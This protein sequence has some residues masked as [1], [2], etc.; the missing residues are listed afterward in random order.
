MGKLYL[1]ER[2]FDNKLISVLRLF[3]DNPDQEFYLREISRESRVPV[4]T[5]FRILKKLR[6]L[7]IIRENHIKKFRIYSL[8]E[9]KN[10]SYLRNIFSEKESVIDYFVKQVSGINE[11]FFIILYGKEEK[12]KASILVIGEGVQNE[13]IK[14]IT[15]EIKEKHGFILNVLTLTK[16]QFNQMSSIGLYSGEKKILF[17]RNI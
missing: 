9:D 15:D 2:L 7:E 13:K 8:I 17:R 11:I 1:L 5:T 6:E 16:E 10:S 12:D 14:E 3:L 4:A